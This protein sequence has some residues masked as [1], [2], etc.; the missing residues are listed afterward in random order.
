[1]VDINPV[2]YQKKK[3]AIDTIGSA[4]DITASIAGLV[5]QGG[6]NKP[7]SEPGYGDAFKRRQLAMAD[8]KK[9]LGL[10]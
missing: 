1:M 2:Q 5:G 6:D 3:N 10:G 7:D 4:S 8:M 9:N